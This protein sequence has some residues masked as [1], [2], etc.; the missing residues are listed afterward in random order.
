MA[1]G[2]AVEID[3]SQVRGHAEAARNLLL[4]LRARYDLSRWEYTRIIRIAPY[5]RSQSH[6]VLTLNLRHLVAGGRDED[7]FL[8]EYLH[9]QVHWA[10][11]IHREDETARAIDRF[12]A[13]Y[14]ELHSGRPE[15]AD[16]EGSTYLHLAVNWL[17]ISATAE[18]LGRERAEAVASGSRIYSRIYRTVIDDHDEIETI[19]TEAGLLPLPSGSATP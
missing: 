3:L 16:N 11:V 4:D 1:G 19:M 12:R 9:E 6:P 2:I 15:T 18:F 5:E 13:A 8:S 7:A 10:L 17:E 14:P